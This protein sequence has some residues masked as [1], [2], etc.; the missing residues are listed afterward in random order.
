MSIA[1]SVALLAVLV[2]AGC[3]DPVHSH[4]VSSLGGEAAGVP[5]GPLHRP[6]QPCLACHSGLGPADSEFI[7]GGTVYQDQ[8]SPTPLPLADARVHFIDSAGK[9]YDTGTNCAGNFFVMA[10]DYKPAYPVWVKVFFGSLN[11]MPAFQQMTSPIYR[12]GSCAMCHVDPAGTSTVSRV[13]LSQVPI[14]IAPSPSCQ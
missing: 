3:S 8:M 5:E 6:G 11:G 12:E 7:F 4:L 1:K 9:T 14:P 10:A 13:Y 2:L